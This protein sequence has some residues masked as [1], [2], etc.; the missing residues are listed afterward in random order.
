MQL[1]DF[2]KEVINVVNDSHLPIDVVYYVF[3]DI[4]GEIANTYSQTLQQEAVEKQKQ[5]E[6]NQTEEE[7]KID[8]KEEE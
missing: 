1:E 5:Q 8:N 7:K 3:K 6:E 4:M 2:K